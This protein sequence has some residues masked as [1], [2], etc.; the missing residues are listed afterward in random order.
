M[1]SQL[2]NQYNSLIMSN[3]MNNFYSAQHQINMQQQSTSNP[4]LFQNVAFNK[5]VFQIYAQLFSSNCHSASTNPVEEQIKGMSET[6]YDLTSHWP[7]VHSIQN[8]VSCN[9]KT[10]ISCNKCLVCLCVDCFKNFHTQTN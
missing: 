8:C 3:Y 2:L 7:S 6:R 5:F 4:L 10:T 9:C 1:T